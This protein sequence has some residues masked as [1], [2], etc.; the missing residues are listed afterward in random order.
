MK[1][2]PCVAGTK[3]RLATVNGRRVIANAIPKQGDLR[4]GWE[5][6]ALDHRRKLWG[7]SRAAYV[8]YQQTR[9]VADQMATVHAFDLFLVAAGGAE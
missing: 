2:V 6:W 1:P 4:Q 5:R 7:E 8:R 3:L 9:F